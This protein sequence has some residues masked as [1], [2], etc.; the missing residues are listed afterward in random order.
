VATGIRKMGN[1]SS[2]PPGAPKQRGSSFVFGSTSRLGQI[3]SAIIPGKMFVGSRTDGMVA[4]M[5]NPHK[6]THILCLEPSSKYPDEGSKLKFLM[7]PLEDDGSSSLEEEFEKIE[8]FLD[9]GVKHG[10][11]LIHCTSGVNRAP[12]V[13]VMYL[14][15]YRGKSLEEAKAVVYSARDGS[16]INPR[17][18]AQLEDFDAGVNPASEGTEG[19]EGN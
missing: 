18:A 14:M 4:K 3:P 8:S 12:T 7:N 17:Y 19:T 9:D 5:G 15:K 13:A 2:M 10:K 16:N 6:F 1:G 11:I